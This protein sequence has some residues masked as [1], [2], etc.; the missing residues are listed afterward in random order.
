MKKIII[1]FLFV[2]YGAI[3][4]CG[5][6][7]E[8][9]INQ[10]LAVKLPTNAEVLT[11]PS[12]LISPTLNTVVFDLKYLSLQIAADKVRELMGSAPGGIIVNE[13][14]LQLE[15]TA[16]LRVIDKIRNL[17]FELDQQRQISLQLKVIQVDLNEEH[18]PGI[19]WSAIVSDFK[20]FSLSAD[21]RNLCVGTIS[22]EDLSVLL[23]A[24]DTVGQIKIFPAG[25]TKIINGQD[26]D[27]RL[28]AF[29]RNVTVSMDLII[30]PV[31]KT[32]EKQDRY[33]ARLILSPAASSQETVDL[34]IISS[35]GA[36]ITIPSAKDQVIVIGGIFTQ[37]KSV[38]TK[39][40]PFLGDI[41]LFGTV[42]RDQ[43]KVVHRL[44]NILILTPRV[45]TPPT[46]GLS[47]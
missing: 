15:V 22:T 3:G 32:N 41:P 31:L 46:N 11:D 45:S 2:F 10:E 20:N 19:N 17:L 26:V 39:K 9:I 36:A 28:K 5:A 7:E 14:S 12:A 21:K 8:V 35:E 43:S 40:F 24:L 37:T 42:F 1:A 18:L 34:R 4:L 38:S 6:Q 30:P 27:L 23:E 33:T 29:D 25:E 13:K 44:E 16:D 47:E